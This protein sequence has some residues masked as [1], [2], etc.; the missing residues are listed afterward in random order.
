MECGGLPPPW[1]PWCVDAAG[2]CR[3]AG[4]QDESWPS[5][6]RVRPTRTGVA[7][8]SEA[9][10]ERRRVRR[11]AHRRVMECGGLPPLWLPSRVDVAGRRRI[12]STPGD[13]RA[14][15]ASS[16]PYANG[17][18]MAQR[19]DGRAPPRPASGAP[20][21]YGVRWLA[22]ALASVP[23]RRCGAPSHQQHARR[24]AGC[25]GVEC[26]WWALGSPPCAECCP[27][28]PTPENAPKHAPRRRR[29]RRPHNRPTR[30]L[31]VPTF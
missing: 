15:A 12:S 5:A 22:T 4:N 7:W 20:A 26:R 17:G 2:R 29:P 19:G 21:R 31:E 28:C 8:P 14:A 16:P 30:A 11:R 9:T 3:S 1:I 6:G 23:R 27:R 25:S 18:G 10:A 24:L 13:S